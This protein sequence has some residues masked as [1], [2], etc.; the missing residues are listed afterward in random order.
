MPSLGAGSPEIV[1]RTFNVTGPVA[2]PFAFVADT[3]AVSPLSGM[4]N[5]KLVAVTEPGTTTSAPSFAV[6]FTPVARKFPPLT[7][8]TPPA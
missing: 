4:V 8:T 6:G 7:V 1:G 5:W 3:E 2:V